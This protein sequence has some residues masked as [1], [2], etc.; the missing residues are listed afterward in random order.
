MRQDT[1]RAAWGVG[2]LGCVLAVLIATAAHA[3]SDA[4]VYAARFVSMQR[5]AGDLYTPLEPVSGAAHPVPL[6]GAVHPSVSARALDAATAYAA[7]NRSRALLV[8]QRGALQYSAYFAG[9]DADAPLASKSPAKPLDAIV[10]GRAI[11][12]GY[13]RSLDQPVS[14]FIPEWRGTAKQRI[15]TKCPRG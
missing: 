15:N 13:V 10:I 8:W 5:G 11:R 14:D 9:A 4:A 7:A 12:L 2:M 6:P 1:H 3:A